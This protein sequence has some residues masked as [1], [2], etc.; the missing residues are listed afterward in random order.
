MPEKMIERVF[1]E[2]RENFEYVS[3]DIQF[4]VLDDWR[5]YTDALGDTW[6]DDCDGFACTLAETFSQRGLPD[7]SIRVVYNR[8]QGVPHL[9]CSV[10]VTERGLA[11]SGFNV[12]HDTIFMD[13][14]GKSPWPWQD[15]FND[16]EFISGMR[17][18]EPGV[19]RAIRS[20]DHASQTS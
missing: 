17:L 11:A 4:G 13:N 7:Y 14:I 12:V 19:W 3:D 9:G 16:Y 15:L 5:T 6:E 1:N 2:V 8:F 10:D 20:T 18:S